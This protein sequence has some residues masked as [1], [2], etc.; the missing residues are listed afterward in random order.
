M[1]SKIII[2]TKDRRTREHFSGYFRDR[3]Y[4]CLAI[5]RNRIIAEQQLALT[6]NGAKFCGQELFAGTAAAIILDSGF[7]W[8]QPATAPTAAQWSAYER[9]LD[10]YLRNEREAAS[11]WYSFLEILNDA[12]P[13]CINPQ[14]AFTAEA[15]KPWALDLLAGNGVTTAPFVAGNNGEEIAKFINTHPGPLLSLP[16]TGDEEESWNP[17]RLFDGHDAPVFLQAFASGE[18]LRTVVANG[19]AIRVHPSGSNIEGVIDQ[20]PLICSCL[21]LHLAELVFRD[22][23]GLVLSDFKAVPDLENLDGQALTSLA[24]EIHTMIRRTCR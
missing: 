7:M 17:P 23:D 6:E 5:E 14:E 12:L 13:I 8:P 15:F 22:S 2:I 10:E 9:N 18:E 24:D 4:E 3:G 11:L 1:K 21:N 19:K 16:I 20:I